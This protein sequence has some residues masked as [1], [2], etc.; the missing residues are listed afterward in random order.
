LAAS[1]HDRLQPGSRQRRLRRP[2][3][4]L[5]AI[6]L[7]A[8][9]GCS[10]EELPGFAM[11]HADDPVT[12]QAPRILSLWQGAWIAAFAVGA[13]VWGLIVAAIIFYR[14]R[15]SD[16]GLPPQVRYNVPIEV[17]YT[18]IPLIMVSVFFFFTARD[19]ERL[20]TVSADPDH[21]IVVTG[22]QWSWQFTYLS[23]GDQNTMVTGTPGKPPTLVLPQGE[24]VKFRL[25]SDDVNH[26]FWV[27]A[28]LFKL[29]VIPGQENVFE[30]TPKETGEYI[31]RCAEFCGQDH[32]RMLFNVRVVSPDEFQTY[33]AD[34]MKAG[35]PA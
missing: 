1:D 6:L 17:M 16:T 18:I 27:P 29:D 22:I 9:T 11:P 30:I 28:F 12:E 7:L 34:V 35:N 23:D 8:L 15:R 21:E 10:S 25:R 26:A 5:T 33:V 24:S 3:V 4:V 31:G 2:Y 14:R 13:I 32:P 20:L 19:E